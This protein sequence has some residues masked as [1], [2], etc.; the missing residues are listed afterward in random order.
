LDLTTG[1]VGNHG[2]GCLEELSEFLIAENYLA[3]PDIWYIQKVMKQS[4]PESSYLEIN[5]ELEKFTVWV[6][7]EYLPLRSTSNDKAE[8][9]EDLCF[10]MQIGFDPLRNLLWS[11]KRF[12]ECTVMVLGVVANLHLLFLQDAAVLDP[13][14]AHPTQSVFYKHMIET[15]EYY[16]IRFEKCYHH[17]KTKRLGM[18]SQL[19]FYVPREEGNMALLAYWTDKMKDNYKFIDY[20]G[21][22]N[23][24][25]KSGTFQQLRERSEK[26]HQE[27]IESIKSEV[28]GK[29][30]YLLE[31]RSKWRTFFGQHCLPTKAYGHFGGYPEPQSN[32]N[33]QSNVGQEVPALEPQG[34]SL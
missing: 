18:I 9:F 30:G 16:A 25:Y 13:H 3:I 26:A 21:Y 22:C 24:V 1:L 19:D 23:N 17:I 14:V 7:T 10:N 34:S 8:I 32:L 6:N 5:N 27:Y 28:L 15:A 12:R 20:I 29:F 31:I 11:I 33:D 4:I 2:I